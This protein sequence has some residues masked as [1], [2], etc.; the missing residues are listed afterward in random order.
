LARRKGVLVTRA[1]SPQAPDVVA[2]IDA[3][4][5]AA[6]GSRLQNRRVAFGNSAP[7]LGVEEI[8]RGA[9]L[10]AETTS[11]LHYTIVTQRHVGGDTIVE[12]NVTDDRKDGQQV[13]MP[14]VT[15]F[16]RDGDGTI[17]DCRVHFVEAPGHDGLAAGVAAV[18]ASAGGIG[19]G[20]A[21]P[22]DGGWLAG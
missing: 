16:H 14:C 22:A 11:A 4:D 1:T 3:M 20:A 10:F 5:V 17:D 19:L 2:V 18:T 13:T 7:L 6:L 12:L 8:H 15:T 21:L 9:T